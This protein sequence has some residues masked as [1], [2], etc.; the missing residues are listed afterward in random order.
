MYIRKAQPKDIPII[1]EIYN[2]AIKS[3]TATFDTTPKTI[4]EQHLWFEDHGPK[5]PV[6]VAEQDG[7]IIAWGSLSK[8]SDRCAYTDTAE[9]SLYVTEPYQGKGIG[10]RLLTQLLE[11][12]HKQ[13]LHA[14]IARIT[15]GN[16]A[17]ISLHESLG[18]FHIGTMK[19]VGVKFGKRLDVH[20]LEK[21]FP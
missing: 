19:E 8:W 4:E 12:G 9:V 3:T 20:L 5:N 14:V 2:E 7:I 13:G 1:T 10:T 18:F 21:L 17:S 15:E 6:M 11:E 16:T